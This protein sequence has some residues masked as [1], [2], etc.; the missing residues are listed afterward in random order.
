MGRSLVGRSA[1]ASSLSTDDASHITG[2]EILVTLTGSWRLGNFHV[3]FRHLTVCR[4]CFL[5]LETDRPEES[6]RHLWN[7]TVNKPD[8]LCTAVSMQRGQ[9]LAA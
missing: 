5:A 4:R 6:I 9:P 2:T 8:K 3:Y 7:E 1:K